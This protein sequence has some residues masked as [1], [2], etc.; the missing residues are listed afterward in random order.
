[1]FKTLS[2]I[3]LT[4]IISSV[5]SVGVLVRYSNIE[6]SEI[7]HIVKNSFQENKNTD[8][9]SKENAIIIDITS[10]PK[11]IDVEKINHDVNTVANAYKGIKM[12][13]SGTIN[14]YSNDKG[15]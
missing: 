10:E 6:L 4:V 3:A 11:Y 2:R 13:I 5:T 12:F 1:M 15:C 7:G 14:N 9:K 8:W